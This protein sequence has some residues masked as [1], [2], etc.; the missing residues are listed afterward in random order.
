[1]TWFSMECK[2]KNIKDIK[3]REIDKFDAYF[4]NVHI[5]LS[6]ATEA[7]KGIVFG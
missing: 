5:S 3:L 4:A 7:F 6:F 2:G 1:M